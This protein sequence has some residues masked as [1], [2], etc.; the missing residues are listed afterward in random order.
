MTQVTLASRSRTHTGGL[1]SL[2]RMK[3]L[4]G[5]NAGFKF[6]RLGGSAFLMTGND[7][8]FS[9]HRAPLQENGNLPRRAGAP[10]S[11]HDTPKARNVWYTISDPAYARTVMYTSCTTG[12]FQLLVSR[13][14]TA[15]VD[16][17]CIART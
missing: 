9:A 10:Y 3:F 11:H 4:T 8:M 15:C 12:H 13:R 1:S 16:R 17:H 5:K 7:K 14:V 2:N 6:L